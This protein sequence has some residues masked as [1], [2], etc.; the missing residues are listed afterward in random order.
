TR[1]SRCHTSSIRHSGDAGLSVPY[2]ALTAS[3]PPPAAFG[4]SPLPSAAKASFIWFFCCL[5]AMRDTSYLPL[6]TV[7]PFGEPTPTMAS[8]DSCTAS[9]GLTTPSVPHPGH[10][11]SLPR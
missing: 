6:H 5:A 4:A 10:V 2:P 3:V 7:R 9:E 11:A 1:L 8:A